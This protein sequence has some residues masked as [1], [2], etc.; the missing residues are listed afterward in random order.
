MKNIFF[1]SYVYTA[2]KDYIG[3]DP[4]DVFEHVPFKT[5]KEAITAAAEDYAIRTDDDDFG[6][7]VVV[8]DG[9]VVL[10]VLRS[11]NIETINPEYE[12]IFDKYFKK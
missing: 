11:R 12:K 5:L 2:E 8:V 6:G 3:S 1:E 9:V 4:Y 7:S 10:N